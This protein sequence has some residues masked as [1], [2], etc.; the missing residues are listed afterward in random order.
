MSAYV[1]WLPGSLLNFE[2]FQQQAEVLFDDATLLVEG[3]ES[4]IFSNIL[5]TFF[6]TDGSEGNSIW[7]YNLLDSS[8]A[9]ARPGPAQLGIQGP[10]AVRSRFFEAYDFFFCTE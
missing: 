10:T 5:K 4:S 1:P 8:R 9:S 7:V 2:I 3:S 6:T